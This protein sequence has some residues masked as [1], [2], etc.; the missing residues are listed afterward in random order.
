MF[1]QLQYYMVLKDV[2]FAAVDLNQL[3]IGCMSVR[4]TGYS[5]VIALGNAGLIHGWDEEVNRLEG[6]LWFEVLADC[7]LDERHDMRF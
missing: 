6:F 5:I 2:R 4:V 1:S 3:W 7:I